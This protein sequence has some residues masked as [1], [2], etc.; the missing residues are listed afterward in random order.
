MEA[1]HRSE[2]L[3]GDERFLRPAFPGSVREL[4]SLYR[5][6]GEGPHPC[7]CQTSYE[8]LTNSTS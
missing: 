3:A 4:C 8:L 6:A 5:A 7:I 1:K 2:G